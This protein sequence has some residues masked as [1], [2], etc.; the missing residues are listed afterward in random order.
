MFKNKVPLPYPLPVC[1]KCPPW[2][3]IFTPTLSH[4]FASPSLRF[5]RCPRMQEGPKGPCG[6][7][8]E[9]GLLRQKVIKVNPHSTPH[10]PLSALPRKVSVEIFRSNYPP[11]GRRQKNAR[12]NTRFWGPKKQKNEFWPVYCHFLARFPKKILQKLYQPS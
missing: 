8:S 12:H 1:S 5:F 10:N 3:H 9:G 2:S 11:P 6:S 4:F 7:F